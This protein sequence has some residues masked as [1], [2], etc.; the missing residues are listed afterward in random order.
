MDNIARFSTKRFYRD[1]VVWQRAVDLVT[2][3]YRRTAL[4]RNQ[5]R[6]GFTS[7]LR[8]AAVSIPSNIAEGQGRVTRG[9]FTQFL[10]QARGSLM[11]IE[12][13][14]I[15]AR[16]LGYLREAEA[17]GLSERTSEVGRML[18]GLAQSIR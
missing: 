10:G 17:S 6:F 18:N 7:Q 1:L 15:I 3:I 11:E 2:E 5:E 13:Q 16:N 9:E 4:F 12:T 8:R 14:L